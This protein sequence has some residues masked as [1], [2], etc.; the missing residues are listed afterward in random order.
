MQNLKQN[1][2]MYCR[3][4]FIIC[5]FK[6]KNKVRV[7]ILFFWESI[8]LSVRPSIHPSV[9]PIFVRDNVLIIFNFYSWCRKK[10]QVW[11]EHRGQ[12][13]IFFIHWEHYWALSLSWQTL[14]KK[15]KFSEKLT[16]VA[17]AGTSV[18]YWQILPLK[19]VWPFF[20]PFLTW[21]VL[22]EWA[23]KLTEQ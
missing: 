15:Q 3:G 23:E 1:V 11:C 20:Q 6:W 18:G 5:P 16:K 7:R 10:W 13:Q 22:Q 12:L 14:I 21:K 17:V 2:E 19:Q 4:P 8:Y 9:C